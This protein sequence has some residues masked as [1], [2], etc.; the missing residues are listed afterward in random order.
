MVALINS[1]AMICCINLEFTWEMKWLLQ[2]LWR[3]TLA[4]NAD[5]TNNSSGL[6]RYKI[7]LMLLINGKKII[8]GHPWLT[9]HN[10]CI[11][12]TTGKVTLEQ[13]TSPHSSLE[14]TTP[15]GCNLSPR[16]HPYGWI[17]PPHE[18]MRDTL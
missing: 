11:D 10:L 16:N 7:C 13:E 1:G 2:K 5:G 6:I 12:W 18:A 9:I 3:P 8:L 14:S 4:R 17:V 15:Q